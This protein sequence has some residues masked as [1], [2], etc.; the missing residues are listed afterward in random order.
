[1]YDLSGTFTTFYQTCKVIGSESETSRLL[2]CELTRKYLEVSAVCYMLQ[3][4][5]AN[6]YDV[7]TPEIILSFGDYS[8]RTYINIMIFKK[9]SFWD[10][11]CAYAATHFTLWQFEPIASSIALNS[12]LKT[13]GYQFPVPRTDLGKPSKKHA[14]K[15]TV[16]RR[17]FN[18]SAPSQ[19]LEVR[20][21][22]LFAA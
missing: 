17:I 7:S 13:S 22:S 6:M 15:I 4:I 10:F 12:K 5:A 19:L 20:R 21:K 14:P 11:L 16:E 9:K 18:F 3:K 2:L 8:A 1:M